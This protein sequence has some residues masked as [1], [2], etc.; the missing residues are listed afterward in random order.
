MCKSSTVP[1][2]YT[3]VRFREILSL[4]KDKS[5]NYT[6]YIPEPGGFCRP[7]WEV[8]RKDFF[9]HKNF[10]RSSI[11]LFALVVVI[12]GV[13]I[14]F[15]ESK[16][17]TKSETKVAATAQATTTFSY[18]GVAGKDALT[19]LKEKTTVE[20]DSSGLV[21]SINMRKADSTQHEYW[22][23]YVNGKMASVGP[24][25]YVTKSSD[26]IEWKIEKY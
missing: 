13:A 7:S 1:L 22:A 4:P 26:K 21:S 10:F 24:A 14:L 2:L 12:I 3:F 15:T 25:S 5:E 8:L 17:F 9:M 11:V 23:F 16:D 19:L 6:W 20:Q 18:P